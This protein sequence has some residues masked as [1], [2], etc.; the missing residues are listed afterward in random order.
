MAFP[1]DSLTIRL[2]RNKYID[3]LPSLLRDQLAWE[4]DS[5]RSFDTVFLTTSDKLQSNLT[6][7]SRTTVRDK[8]GAN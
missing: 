1:Q 5:N 4:E 7:V 6:K 8:E 2:E 3:I